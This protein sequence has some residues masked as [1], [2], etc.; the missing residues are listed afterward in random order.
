MTSGTLSSAL[1]CLII[2]SHCLAVWARHSPSPTVELI[3][4]K[5][6]RAEPARDRFMKVSGRTLW[7][8]DLEKSLNFLI[9]RG[10]LGEGESGVFGE[11]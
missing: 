6:I 5:D 2:V 3:A 8:V 11:R 1:A 7:S 9:Q 10:F 4:T